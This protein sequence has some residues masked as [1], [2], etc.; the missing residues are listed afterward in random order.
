M[1][2]GEVK[3]YLKNIEQEYYI[4]LEEE[5]RAGTTTREELERDKEEYR[6]LIK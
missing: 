2:D 4:I 6:R 1:S 3:D 5:Y